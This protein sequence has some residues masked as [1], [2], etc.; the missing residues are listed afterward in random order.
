M[1]PTKLVG[2]VV[3]MRDGRSASASLVGLRNVIFL[4]L[5]V[6]LLAKSNTTPDLVIQYIVRAVFTFSDKPGAGSL[7]NTSGFAFA[8]FPVLPQ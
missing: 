2:F 4:G 3:T 6:S 8:P 7:S 1:R 5:Q